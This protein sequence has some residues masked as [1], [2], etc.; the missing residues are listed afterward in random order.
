VLFIGSSTL[1]LHFCPSVSNDITHVGAV[2]AVPVCWGWCSLAIDSCL[3]WFPR[4][5]RV[6]FR[7]AAMFRADIAC[8]C[9]GPL[10]VAMLQCCNVAMVLPCEA[11]GCLPKSGVAWVGSD[12]WLPPAS[13]SECDSKWRKCLFGRLLFC[14]L[15]GKEGFAKRATRNEM[16][17]HG[18]VLM[19]GLL[20]VM[21]IPRVGDALL[22][23]SLVNGRTAGT[24]I[25][26]RIG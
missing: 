1:C 20:P 17:R 15:V 14:S 6:T 26:A 19:A 25:D 7:I 24:M 3:L 16:W 18:G 21:V 11:G 13:N 4:S 2:Y 22:A 12:G 23:C 10:N 5:V 9:C 8:A